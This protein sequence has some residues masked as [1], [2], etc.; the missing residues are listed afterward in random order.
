MIN[1]FTKFYFG[2]PLQDWLIALATLSFIVLLIKV[3]KRIGLRYLKKWSLN[4]E[5]TLDDFLLETTE[6]SFIP[7]FYLGALHLSLNILTLTPKIDSVIHVASLIFITFFILL[8]I[9]ALLKK[10]VFSFIKSTENSETKEKQAKGLLIILNCVI[11]VLGIVFIIDNLGYNVTTLITG[12]GI[13][14]IAIAL[15][16]QT[17][18]GDLFSYFVIF[19]DKPFEIGDFIIV[20]NNT[21]TIEYVGIKTTR[22]RTLSGEQLI[23]SNTYLT[24]AQVHN[25]KRMEKR[26]VVFNLGVTY[27]TETEKI[28]MIPHKV[29]EIIE[30]KTEVLFDRG[31][32][33]GFGNFSLDFEFVY[34]VLSAEYNIYMDKQ[35]EIYFDILSRFEEEK[36][37]FA[38]PTQTIFTIPEAVNSEYQN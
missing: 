30:S 2:N 36:I 34:Y 27:Q 13:G 6:K 24:N 9:T 4:T 20:E 35:Q 31:H 8:I 1:F 14:G 19:F 11:W 26:R 29:Q 5:T 22:I 32:F 23:C 12:L 21:G 16:A 37:E 17:I 15:A 10:F 38:Y 18:L 3:F 28:K 25:Y 33:S 7:L